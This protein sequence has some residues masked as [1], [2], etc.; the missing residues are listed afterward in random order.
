MS[1][2]LRCDQLVVV[3]RV[4]ASEVI[5]L[6]GLDLTIAAG[7]MVGII[8]SSGS[9][10]STLL[11]VVSGLLRPT[12]GSVS[13][14]GL[15][16]GHASRR[17]LDRY[18]SCDVGF[19]WQDSTHNLIPYLTALDNVIIPLAGQS[20]GEASRRGAELLRRVGLD[21]RLDHRPA[22]LSG[23]ERAR[24]ALAVALA[25]RP[26]LLL[27]DEPTGEL[28]RETTEAVFGLMREIGAETGLTQIVVSHDD[29]ITSHVDRVVSLRDGRIAAEQRLTRN[30]SGETEI[31]EV[32]MIDTIGRLQLTHDQRALIGDS[33]RVHTEIV[34]DEVRIRAADLEQRGE[35]RD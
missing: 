18:R 24:L 15:D 28:D 31:V 13:F 16:L 30:A 21:Q 33:G 7:E 2:L 1:D 4:G 10:K 11:S 25:H 3:Y 6:Q 8:G 9:G 19:V 23:G 12:G 22:E 35:S 26:R 32:T 17:R 27:A 5:A 29:E 34:G 14:D 20:R